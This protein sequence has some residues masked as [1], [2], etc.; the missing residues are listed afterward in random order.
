MTG[1]RS[2]YVPRGRPS[3]A[4][5]CRSSGSTNRR[6]SLLA[7]ENRTSLLGCIREQGVENHFQPLSDEPRPDASASHP[8]FFPAG[9]GRF[10][11]EPKSI[12][13]LRGLRR[14]RLIN[15]RQEPEPGE[16]LGP[17]TGVTVRV[18]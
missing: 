18:H 11:L 15:I 8:V 7:D 17:R 14:Q 6:R 16:T 1:V 3:G 4:W 2:V 12:K 13:L 9:L 5:E 10:G